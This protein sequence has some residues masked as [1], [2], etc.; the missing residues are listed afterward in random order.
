MFGF[1][2]LGIQRGMRRVILKKFLG[3]SPFLDEPMLPEVF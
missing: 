3:L 1:L 2:Q